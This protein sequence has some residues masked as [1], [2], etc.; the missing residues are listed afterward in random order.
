MDQKKLGDNS[1]QKNDPGPERTNDKVF[2]KITTDVV[3]FY[4][5]NH[6]ILIETFV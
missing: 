1:D 5:N 4:F 6:L 2:Y 3:A